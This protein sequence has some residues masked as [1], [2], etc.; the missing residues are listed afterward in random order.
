MD[1]LEHRRIQPYALLPSTLWDAHAIKY[2]DTVPSHEARTAIRSALQH[3]IGKLFYE[4]KSPLT[5]RK[6]TA[7]K[8]KRWTS[9]INV[10]K[11]VENGLVSH[12]TATKC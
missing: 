12:E 8:Q 4:C 5:P 1:R 2:N 10:Q 6:R 3:P 11:E 9:L 7:T